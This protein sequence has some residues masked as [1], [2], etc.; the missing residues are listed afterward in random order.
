[1]GLSVQNHDGEVNREMKLRSRRKGAKDAKEMRTDKTTSRDLVFFAAW[2]LCAFALI[3]SQLHDFIF[4]SGSAI[5]YDEGADD[6]GDDACSD[7]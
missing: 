7:S 5:M 4:H 2:H 1:M 3:S 6:I